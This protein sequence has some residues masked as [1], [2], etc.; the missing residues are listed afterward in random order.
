MVIIGIDPHKGSHTAAALGNGADV[1]AQVRVP[2]NKATLSRFLKWAAPW[3]ERR[4][5]IEGATGL[6]L[7]LAQQLV[8]AGETVVDVPAN[9]AA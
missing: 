5:A 4:W 3:P 1:L 6:G 2:A 7:L 8:S 9:L